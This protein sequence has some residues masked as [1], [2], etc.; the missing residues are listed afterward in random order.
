MRTPSRR[1][2][3]AELPVP[4]SAGPAPAAPLAARVLTVLVAVTGAA[5]FT[6]SGPVIFA[7]SSAA[8]FYAALSGPVR[9][10]HRTIVA[11]VL[12]SAVTVTWSV[13]PA[14][15]VNGVLILAVSTLALWGLVQQ[16]PREQVY[17]ALAAA[18][19][20]LLVGSL[21]VYLALPAVGREQTA[22]HY[23]ALRGLFVQRNVAA[24]VLAAGLLLFVYLAMSP[25]FRPRGRWAAWALFTLVM[26]LA[27]ES[28]TGLAVGVVSCAAL[29]FLMRLHRWKRSVRQLLAVLLAGVTTVAVAGTLQDLAWV[30]RLLG[31]DDTLTGRTF[32]WSLVRPYIEAEPWTGYGWA[33]LWTPESAMTR[34]MWSVAKFPFPHAHNAYLDAVAQV[35]A[36]GLTLLLLV[37][38]TVVLVAGRRIVSGADGAWP[39]WPF[40]VT[41]FLL[42]YGISENSFLSYFGWNLLVIALALL[43][44]SRPVAGH[45]YGQVAGAGRAVAVPGVQG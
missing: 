5:P 37:C 30:S 6:M 10:P 39:V 12:W 41:F 23:G 16:L 9:M 1:E 2:S 25:S 44:A 18:V 3:P 42:L 14:Q 19:K 22:D 32:I 8:L 24:F 20:L 15:S 36:V 34:A 38:S 29:V 31:R 11:F 43:V 33:A 27:T 35:G 40:V 13:V 26:L 7:L 28:S 21:L 4:A 45:R 17:L